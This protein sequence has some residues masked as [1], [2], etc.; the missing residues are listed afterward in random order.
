MTVT[1]SGPQADARRLNALVRPDGSVVIPPRLTPW[2]R[3]LLE[4]ALMDVRRA[5]RGGD[6][7]ADVLETIDALTLSE[8]SDK[9]RLT[10]Y[11]STLEVEVMGDVSERFMTSSQA[12]SILE[13]TERTVRRALQE[14]RLSG[15]KSGP[16][17]WLI[18]HQE[19]ENFRFGKRNH[20]SN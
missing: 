15:W 13:C 3:S 7:S 14:G 10:G 8:M 1:E 12:A 16:R 11:F 5:G 18:T 17:Q 9:G 4:G 6:L 19:L 2:V 20:G